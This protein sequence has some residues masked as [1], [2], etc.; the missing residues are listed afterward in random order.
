MKKSKKVLSSVLAV[1]C[2]FGV[3][4]ASGCGKKVANDE[5]TLEIYIGNFGYGTQWLDKEIEL[6]KEQAWV[7]EKYPNL[8]IP[9]PSSN[10]DREYS[11]NKIAAG[12]SANTIDLFFS[13]T[14]ASGR[15]ATKAA[16]GSALFEDLSDVYDST[17]PGEEIELKNK[18]LSDIYATQSAEVEGKTVYY[19]MPWVNGYEGLLYNKTL[20]DRLYGGSDYTM[21]RT[22]DE[23]LA[24]AEK[25]RVEDTSRSV[26]VSS[27]KYGYWMNATVLWWS[28]YE[29]LANYV[30]YWNGVNE[31]N[32][33]IAADVIGQKGRLRALEVTESLLGRRNVNGTEVTYIHSD[34]NVME[35]TQAQ[36]KFLAGESYI[37]QNGDWFENEMRETAAENP[38]NY[39]LRFMRTPVISSITEKCKTV[40]TDADLAKVVDCVDAGMDYE[41]T[42]AAYTSGELSQADY[43]KIKEARTLMYRVVGHEAY[44]PSYATAKDLAKDFLRFLSTDIAIEAFTTVTNGV[45]TPYSYDL[46]AKN[47]SF[48][49]SLPEIHK[50]R[51]EISK[52]GVSLPPYTSFKLHYLG[53]H[54][55]FVKTANIESSFTSKNSKDRKTAQQIYQADID[56]YTDAVW[57]TMLQKAGLL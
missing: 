7:K 40:K 12:S 55:T 46:Q 21:P 54:Y 43:N 27:S 49:Q 56:Y 10:S 13:T 18:M 15:Y 3:A 31:A 8:E 4:G 38:N 29:G 16:N 14:S 42:K 51:L 39:V 19:A 17:V 34:T 47:A 25:I 2:L 20:M 24:L 35:F 45:S 48:Y 5:N 11:A 37:M 41:A 30:N 6:F 50:S 52:T 53:G 44:I 32:Q 57:N 9:T 1:S 22:T 36:S 23:L 26:F 33:R 28:Q